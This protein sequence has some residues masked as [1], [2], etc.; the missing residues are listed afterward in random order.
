MLAGHLVDGVHLVGAAYDVGYVAGAEHRVAVRYYRLAPAQQR[1]HLD[2]QVAVGMH[3]VLDG[4]VHHGR[5]ALKAYD[6]HRQQPPAEVE[7][8]RGR[9]VVEQVG[10]LFGGDALGA[11]H[12]VYAQ[13]A[14]HLAMLGAEQLG[15]GDARH[16]ALGLELLGQHAG[17]EVDALVVQHGEEKVAVAH[18]GVLEHLRRRGVADDGQ[19][20]RL[21]LQPAEQL[22]VRVDDGDVVV[23]FR[24]RLGEVHTHLTVACDYDIHGVTF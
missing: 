15:V 17:H 12:L 21:A 23:Q 20:V 24:Q 11:H 9:R 19:Q 10:D 18:A 5:V 8:L 6:V 7:E 1:H 14:H 13:L 4:V 2:L 16:G 22:G 3:E